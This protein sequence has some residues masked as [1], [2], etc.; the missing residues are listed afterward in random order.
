[1]G[2]SPAPSLTNENS[3]PFQRREEICE[4]KQDF[5]ARRS[6]ETQSGVTTTK[7]STLMNADLN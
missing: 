6:T 4:K 3:L 5:E 1:M 2:A 7:S